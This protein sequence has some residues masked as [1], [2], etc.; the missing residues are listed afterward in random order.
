VIVI[1]T[2]TTVGMKFIPGHA[3]LQMGPNSHVMQMAQGEDSG[4]H[5]P[6]PQHGSKKDCQFCRLTE[7]L[8][9]PETPAMFALRGWTMVRDT[10]PAPRLR[11]TGDTQYSLGARAPPSSNSDET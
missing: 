4:H 10:P 3:G 5:M 8:I 9:P 7:T 11:M 2:V 6:A 1:L